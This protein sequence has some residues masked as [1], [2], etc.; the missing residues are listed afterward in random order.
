M[1]YC[2]KIIFIACL[3]KIPLITYAQQ[4]DLGTCNILNMAYNHNEKISFFGEWHLRS[5]KF[6]EHFH[7][8]KINDESGRDF[9][10][11]GFYYELFRKTNR[12]F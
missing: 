1:N 5:L 11:A 12:V 8:Y 2:Y 9:L 6:Y 10:V 7:Y 3:A 4:Y